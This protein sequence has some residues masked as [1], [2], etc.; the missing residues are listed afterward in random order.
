MHGSA[1]A[2]EP[3]LDGNRPERQHRNT[4]NGLQAASKRAG[5]QGRE[6]CVELAPALGRLSKALMPWVGK[7]GRPRQA[8]CRPWAEEGP[9]YDT[10]AVP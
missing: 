2:I 8:A 7:A 5:G 10:G 1:L 3:E 4:R 6:A 9:F